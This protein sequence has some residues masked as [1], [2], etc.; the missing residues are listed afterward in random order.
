MN[1]S[2]VRLTLPELNI[3]PGKEYRLNIVNRVDFNGRTVINSEA[4]SLTQ[5]IEVIRVVQ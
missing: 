3:I 2:A 4:Q 1:R 5:T